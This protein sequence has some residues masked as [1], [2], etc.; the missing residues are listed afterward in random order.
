MGAGDFYSLPDG[1][2]GISRMRFQHLCVCVREK[3]PE[4]IFN[5]I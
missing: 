2:K 3:K 4:V 5:F 1:M